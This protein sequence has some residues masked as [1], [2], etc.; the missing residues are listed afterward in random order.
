[1]LATLQ[2]LP[3]PSSQRE[4]ITLLCVSQSREDESA[5]HDIFVNPQWSLRHASGLH[6]ASR[7]LF[8]GQPSVVICDRK[9]SD[10]D[11]RELLTLASH[12]PC[13]PPVV[14][15]SKNGDDALWAEV[16]NLGG[17]DVLL[18][19]FEKAEVLRVIT[20]AWRQHE[21]LVLRS[22]AKLLVP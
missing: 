3:S 14:V 8:E 7:L 18:K 6:E 16:L 21:T 11:W 1:M 4:K 2:N 10:G 17:Y 22:G 15:V 13:P 12:C 19:P 5:L 9:L 20:M